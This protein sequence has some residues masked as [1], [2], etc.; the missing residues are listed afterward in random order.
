MFSL[1]CTGKKEKIN[2]NTHKLPLFFSK[3]FLFYILD[4]AILIV[5]CRVNY[6]FNADWAACTCHVSCPN[7]LEI[8]DP[9]KFRGFFGVTQNLQYSK[10]AILKNPQFREI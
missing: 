1:H 4:P 8:M 3:H 2:T 6:H 9:T 10:T 5:F 7:R